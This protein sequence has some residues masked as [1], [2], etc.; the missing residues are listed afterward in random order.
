MRIL[1]ID[2]STREDVAKVI[3][4]AKE[5]QYD[6]HM[7]KLLISGDLDSP[8]DNPDYVVHIHD[9]YRVVYTLEQH[10][11]GLCH[12][13]SVSVE[14]SSKYPHELAVQ[15]IMELFGMDK[16]YEKCLQVWPEKISESVNVL[17]EAKDV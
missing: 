1:Q 10:K 9:G 5:H 4:Y 16:E 8:G 6:I 2:D 7:I 12:H 14:K 11:I 17:Q 13:M 3:A 15:M